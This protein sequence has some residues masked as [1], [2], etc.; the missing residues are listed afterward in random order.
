MS[1]VYTQK[2]LHIWYGLPEAMEAEQAFEDG[3]LSK[4]AKTTELIARL[5]LLGEGPNQQRAAKRPGLQPWGD[6]HEVR[7]KLQILFWPGVRRPKD[8]VYF[9][10]QSG[11]PANRLRQVCVCSNECVANYATHARA[12][13]LQHTVLRI[14]CF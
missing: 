9:G 8:P 12:P 14:T 2:R 10:A 7:L 1:L 3:L 4:M 6:Q 13:R 11:G 5:D